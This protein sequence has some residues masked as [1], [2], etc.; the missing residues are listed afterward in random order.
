MG[1]QH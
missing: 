1:M